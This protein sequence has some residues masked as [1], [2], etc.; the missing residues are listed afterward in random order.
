M[1]PIIATNCWLRH[2]AHRRR[3]KGF[4]FFTL[5]TH[6]VSLWLLHKCVHNQY[7]LTTI[8]IKYIRATLLWFH[9]ISLQIV[10]CYQV[11]VKCCKSN[12]AHTKIVSSFFCG[13]TEDTTND[14]DK[15]CGMLTRVPMKVIEPKR[16]EN[17]SKFNDFPDHL[18]FGKMS[19]TNT[20]ALI[21][22]RY[23]LMIAFMRL[24]S[25]ARHRTRSEKSIINNAKIVCYEYEWRFFP[26][27]PL[28][29]DFVVTVNDSPWDWVKCAQICVRRH[30][31]NYAWCDC[32]MALFSISPLAPETT[33]TKTRLMARY[34]NSIK[35]PAIESV[36]SIWAFR[37]RFVFVYRSLWNR[38]SI[39]RYEIW[40]AKMDDTIGTARH[41]TIDPMSQPFS[42]YNVLSKSFKLIEWM[43]EWMT[44]SNN[45]IER[46][47]EMAWTHGIALCF[48]I[49]W[50]L[51]D[52]LQHYKLISCCD[53]ALF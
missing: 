31:Q 3:A 12:K 49:F 42:N 34:A 52:Q 6:Y 23:G 19:L 4:H 16:T 53:S 48:P 5:D 17:V 11:S 13:K 39:M 41:G 33:R 18:Q 24:K 51:L 25:G 43:N 26:S 10:K 40:A 21:R 20:F 46:S 47:C 9:C 35:S 1:P 50:T 2:K 37:C 22:I 32:K 38:I 7:K 36:R 45:S 44:T 14:S 8:Q 15:M 28:R 27:C 30:L 29:N